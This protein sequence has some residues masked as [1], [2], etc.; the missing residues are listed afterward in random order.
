[1]CAMHKTFDDII[2]DLIE[3][4]VDDIIVKIKS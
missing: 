2:R 3:V 4:Y 1:V